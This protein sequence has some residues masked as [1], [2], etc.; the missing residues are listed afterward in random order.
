[1]LETLMIFIGMAAICLACALMGGLV[2]Y[3][4]ARHVETN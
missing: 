2:G 4:L 1:M 3:L